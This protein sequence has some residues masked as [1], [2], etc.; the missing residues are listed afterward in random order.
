MRL[1]TFILLFS[2]FFLKTYSQIR[3]EVERATISI[4]EFNSIKVYSGLEVKLIPSD[5]NVL[6]VYGDNIEKVIISIKRKS[7]CVI[8]IANFSII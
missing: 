3:Y 1:K 6:Y 5:K 8:S 7:S 4:K 2:L